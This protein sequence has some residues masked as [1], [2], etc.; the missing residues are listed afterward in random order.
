MKSGQG[1][2]CAVSMQ[3]K[4]NVKY[5]RWII[6]FAGTL[7]LFC[8]GGLLLTGFNVY[9]P[10]LISEGGLNDTQLST[11][12]MMRNLFSLL[13][14]FAVIP[15]LRKL[16]I[17]LGISAAILIAALSFF[18]FSIGRH[19][20]V[21]CIGMGMAGISYGLGG[22][23][24]V[25]VII[26]RWFSD[27]EGLALGICAAGTGLSAV[28]ASPVITYIT[29]NRSLE[30]SFRIE[31]FFLLAAAALAFFLIHNYPDKKGK[32]LP[33][34]KEQT[35]KQRRKNRF[36]L[37]YGQIILLF[38]GVFLGGAS[39]N[40]SAFLSVL[41]REKGFDAGTVASLVSLMGL[42]LCAGKCVYGLAAD[43]MGKIR[44]G[45]LFHIC[46]IAAVLLC[47]VC[48]PGNTVMAYT[49]M[50]LLGLGFPMLSVGLS[51][52]AGAAA[53]EGFYAEVLRQFQI[54]YMVGTLSFGI[55]PGVLADM[56][57]N[58]TISYYLLTIIALAAALL[59]QGVL[60]KNAKNKEMANGKIER[61][62]GNKESK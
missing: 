25:S 23:V 47:A 42:A 18:M 20:A 43:H 40:V 50:V 34:I 8:T 51:Q 13:A 14:M 27:N 62:S 2:K 5:Y 11:V 57:G 41:Y 19:Y 10:Y 3:K 44:S 24:P 56:A 16:D 15:Y 46:Y 1:Q 31:T 21:Y 61:I 52:L 12:L 37:A 36:S 17:R 54:V 39:F 35:A 26:K 32:S 4:I 38:I 7:T 29:E 58:Y 22:M 49:A 59:Q 9:T 53:K 28:V 55:V 45:N 6:C 30:E 60:M 48:I 33:K